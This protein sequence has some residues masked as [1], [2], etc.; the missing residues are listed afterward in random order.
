M[1]FLI[2]SL[3]LPVHVAE[4]ILI[5]HNLG[6]L[7]CW[8]GLGGP[9]AGFASGLQRGK[10]KHAIAHP[11]EKKKKLFFFILF[12]SYLLFQ[13]ASPKGNMNLFFGSYSMALNSL[14]LLVMTDVVVGYYSD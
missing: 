4:T 1:Y 5:L 13:K 6:D 12:P 10:K 9:R 7:G 14:C 2:N 8:L 11:I 3:V